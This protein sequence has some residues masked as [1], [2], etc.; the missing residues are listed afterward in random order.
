MLTIIARER[1]FVTEGGTLETGT[2]LV[3]DVKG[4]YIMG[5]IK[6]KKRKNT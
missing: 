5:E 2:A 6:L 4:C 3:K 1:F